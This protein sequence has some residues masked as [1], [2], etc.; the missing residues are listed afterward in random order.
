MDRRKVT[1]TIKKV[2][3]NLKETTK[4]INIRQFETPGPKTESEIKLHKAHVDAHNQLGL[5]NLLALI[6]LITLIVIFILHF[7]GKVA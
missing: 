1:T 5:I 7:I 4:P 3:V 6:F 2:G